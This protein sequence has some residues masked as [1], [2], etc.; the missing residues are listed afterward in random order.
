MA[1]SVN[2]APVIPAKAGI[3]Y[4]AESYGRFP[5]Q[6]RHFHTE[7]T[8]ERKGFAGFPPSRE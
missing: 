1:L 8:K 6:E 5:E 3:Q 4:N 2:K 7:T